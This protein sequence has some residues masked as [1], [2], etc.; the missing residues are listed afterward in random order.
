MSYTKELNR[1]NRA[2]LIPYLLGRFISHHLLQALQDVGKI[3]LCAPSAMRAL[4]CPLSHV[5]QVLL[6]LP[7]ST[8][9][10]QAA[11]RS[12]K[13]GHYQHSVKLRILNSRVSSTSCSELHQQRPDSPGE[14]CTASARARYPIYVRLQRSNLHVKRITTD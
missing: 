12:Q 5:L 2:P 1:P 13:I 4:H 14:H 6:R 10:A 7:I 9:P 3:S 11:T 8:L